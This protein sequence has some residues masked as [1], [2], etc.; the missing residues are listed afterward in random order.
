MS[1]NPE[2]CTTDGAFGTCVVSGFGLLPCPVQGP[3]NS[4]IC[5]PLCTVTQLCTS[6]SREAFTGGCDFRVWLPS[7]QGLL[8]AAPDEAPLRVVRLGPLEAVHESVRQ[9]HIDVLS[10][11]AART[12]AALSAEKG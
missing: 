6:L 9:L 12:D 11:Q 2:C 4:L 10:S 8:G 3:A 7:D 5:V 1:T